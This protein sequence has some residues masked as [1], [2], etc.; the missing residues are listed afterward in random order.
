MSSG[1]IAYIVLF[2]I[3][4]LLLVIV[5]DDDGPRYP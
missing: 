4:A 5:F 3:L 2:A 1:I